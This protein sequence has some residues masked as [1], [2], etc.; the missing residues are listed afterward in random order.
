MSQGQTLPFLP[1]AGQEPV[2]S[3]YEAL[4]KVGRGGM[5]VVYRARH[6]MLDKQVAVKFCLPGREIERF[7][8]EA[9]LLGS[10]RSPYI[11]AVHDFDLL[12]DG[13]AM[14]VMDWVEGRDLAKLLREKNGPLP[15][16][17][18]LPWMLQVCQG[19]QAA[20]NQNIVHRDLKPS[21]ILLDRHDQAQV[22][23]FGLARSASVDQLST[24]GGLM[25]TPHYMAPEQAED[26][27]GVDT[28]ADIYSFGATF[29][30]ALTGKPP[31]DGPTPF[32]VLYKHKTEPLVSPRVRCPNLSER[33]SELLER[34]LAKSPVDRFPSFTELL[35]HLQPSPGASSPWVISDDSELAEYQ[36]RYDARKLY[37][38]MEDQLWNED[39]DAYTF[40][41]GQTLRIMR[42]DLVAQEVDALVSSDTCN[43]DMDGGVAAA[44]QRAG[45]PE[46]MNQI[47]TQRPARPGRAV[48][49]SAGDLPARFVFH[50]VTVGYVEGELVR[51]SRDI[52]I[53][54]MTSC[55]YHADSF[56]VRSIAFPLLATGG[57]GF[58][59]PICLDTMFQ[60]LARLFLRGLTSVREARIV[61][62][63]D[64]GFFP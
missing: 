40:P 24:T 29:Y 1:E 59:R 35:R 63:K 44:I 19:M 57:Q 33:T 11:V 52:I 61:I 36:V 50:G 8:R 60:F 39:L 43:L 38:L 18:V 3:R 5:G 31:F 27:R 54:I 9:K 41:R 34:C 12:P 17:R 30:H 42:G 15:E 58:P 20:A 47:V 10:L 2:L 21:N 37:Y 49:T 56:E 64:Q 51:A 45:G 46:I 13:R 7:Q 55:F 32:A 16:R 23:D 6:R 62:Y 22:A 25:G 26:P 48:V 28:R 4:E 14:L 53:E